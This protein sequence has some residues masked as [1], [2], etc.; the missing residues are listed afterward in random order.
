MPGSLLLISKQVQPKS[1]KR[2]SKLIVERKDKF[3]LNVCR[4]NARFV[5]L[6][7]CAVG[8]LVINIM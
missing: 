5:L 2:I 8:E 1:S 4:G 7:E 6:A 3:L